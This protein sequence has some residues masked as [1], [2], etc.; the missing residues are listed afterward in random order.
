MLDNQ[1]APRVQMKDSSIESFVS[2]L[3]KEGVTKKIDN[4]RV[5]IDLLST[6]T[7]REEETVR[8]RHGFEPYQP[9]TLRQVGE[10]FSLGAERVRQI[11]NKA[12]RKLRWIIYHHYDIDDDLALAAFL[13]QRAEK[14]TEQQQILER[15]KTAKAAKAHD[16]EQKRRAKEQRDSARRIKA[17]ATAWER[18]LKKAES[19]H[20]ALKDESHIL[21]QRISSLERRGWFARTI[22]PHESKL[23][24][25][26]KKAEQLRQ[27]I[28]VTGAAVGKIR[29]SP[30]RSEGE[31]DDHDCGEP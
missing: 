20:Q 22:L 26:R 13:K 15:A 12:F 4:P 19:E 11:E 6:L 2:R 27:A 18:R 29:G 31:D 28:E 25:M 24:V 14:G 7:A 5:V 23:A 3:E 16:I 9:H 21:Q 10:V 1:E 8:R 17:R 30:P